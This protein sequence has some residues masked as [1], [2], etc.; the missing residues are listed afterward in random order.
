VE[1]AAVQLDLSTV[2]QSVAAV[3]ES[4]V[5]DT[6][7]LQAPENGPTITGSVTFR[8]YGPDDPTCSDAPVFT[9]STPVPAEDFLPGLALV[10]SDPTTFTE[11]GVYRWVAS[12]SGDEN[13]EAVTAP[14]NAPEEQTY[15]YE[16]SDSLTMFTDA[17]PDTVA[18]GE[19]TSDLAY[20][21]TPDEA[22]PDPTGSV[23][24]SLY[25]PDDDTCSDA[26]VFTSNDRPVD[27]DV[28]TAES[29]EFLPTEP[30]TYR[31]RAE[32]SGDETYDPISHPCNAPLETL[33][34][35]AGDEPTGLV[36]NDD[37]YELE[38]NSVGFTLEPPV[39][40]NDT[41]AVKSVVV[42]TPPEH[43]V[44]NHTSSTTL[45]YTPDA[46]FDGVDTFTYRAEGTGGE[47]PS[48]TATVTLTVTPEDHGGGDG[49]YTAVND[50]YTVAQDSGPTSLTPTIY[51]ND[52][53][54]PLGSYTVN[55]TD[56]AHGNVHIDVLTTYTP[57]P[58]FSG[59]DTFT[60]RYDYDTGDGPRETNTATVTITVTPSGD[61]GDP[62]DDED[63]GDGEG[64]HDDD[65]GKNGGKLPD[66]G[67]TAT[68]RLLFMS[69]L[70]SI[71]GLLLIAH[72][73]RRI[74]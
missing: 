5:E 73:R 1:A 63:G 34:V 48:N 24:F 57:D 53:S 26:P 18:V 17:T 9:G 54:P 66:T 15:I 13:Y 49:P 14:C 44:L 33:T 55:H 38:E 6:A 70:L 28:A 22:D 61:P 65:D 43:G 36:A 20:F 42:V 56:P 29:D 47:D 3:G 60:Y 12:Y 8:A 19:G 46:G 10:D 67:G 59:V 41:G 69:M 58:G 2:A 21:V 4:G 23:S 51:E 50:S 30:G 71:G 7:F 62:N 32:Y 27:P 52:A 11:P 35:T 64:D 16:P 37:A 74:H 45:Q 68:A 39:T 31:W 72:T 40:A 25:G